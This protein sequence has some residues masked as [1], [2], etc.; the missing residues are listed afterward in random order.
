[1]KKFIIIGIIIGLVILIAVLIP[2][3][4]PAEEPAIEGPVLGAPVANPEP[5]FF[6]AEEIIL[7]GKIMNG[8][9]TFNINE[10]MALPMLKEKL[11][12]NSG[13]GH[14]EYLNMSFNKNDVEVIREL[15][16]L[17]NK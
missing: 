16:K 4:K 5:V 3:D 12:H 10:L 6:G 8:Q 9:E 13:I 2:K 15:N 11:I 7:N 17:L 1:M 14:A